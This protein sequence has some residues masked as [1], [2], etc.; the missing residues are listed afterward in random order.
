MTTVFDI[1]IIGAGFAGLIAAQDLKQAGYSVILLEKSRGVGGRCATRRVS[2]IPVDHGVRYL[3]ATGKQTQNLIQQLTATNVL[4]LW[5]DKID[6]FKDNQLQPQQTQPLYI[7]PNGMNSVGKELAVG[8]DIWFNRRVERLTP[9]L[10]K[11]WYLSLEVTHPTAT[12]NPEEVEAKAVILAIPAPQALL[13]LEPLTAE[14]PANF[15]EQVRS[16]EYNACITVMAG[17]EF[18]HTP[19]WKAIT[20]PENETIA[21]VSLDSS[22]RDNP[23]QTVLVV[24]SSA[25]FAE[26]YL[27]TTDLQPVGEMLL[28]AA[29]DYL[30]LGKPEWMQVHR[31]KYAFCRKP[32]TVPCLTT[33]TPLP[34]VCAGDW[35]GESQI[36]TALASGKAAA[37][38]FQD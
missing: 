18:T 15:V 3:E 38:F 6:V 23:K 21:W 13:L 35:C 22:K 7:A 29:T 25:K 32:L 28:N 26:D 14:L 34:L 36:E 16:V 5:M 4:Q 33:I 17:Y 20:F 1:A 8:L 30:S 24:Q 9:T 37:Q 27:D 11:T 31:W 19:P 10:N 12:E 2:D